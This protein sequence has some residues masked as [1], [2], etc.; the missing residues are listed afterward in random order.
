M[1]NGPVLVLNMM[2]WTEFMRVGG[3]GFSSIPVTKVE[4]KCHRSPSLKSN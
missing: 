1:D 2:E 3:L 4:I